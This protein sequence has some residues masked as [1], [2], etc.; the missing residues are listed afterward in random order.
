VVVQ[1]NMTLPSI[2]DTPRIVAMIGAG[3]FYTISCAASNYIYLVA[4]MPTSISLANEEA[5]VL[6]SSDTSQNIWVPIANIA[7]VGA[8]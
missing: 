8:L 2:T 5:L 6:F 1:A 4:S 3:A 7:D